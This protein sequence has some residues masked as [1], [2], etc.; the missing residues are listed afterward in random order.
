MTTRL[1]RTTTAALAI[2]AG[3]GLAT[4]PGDARADPAQAATG[5]VPEAAIQEA[6]GLVRSFSANLKGELQAAIR[7]GGPAHAIGVCREAAP[8]IAGNLSETRGWAVGRT[9]LR[10]RNPRNSPSVRERAVLMDFKQRHAAGE[11]LETMESAAV[12]QHGGRR[13]LHYMKAIPTQQVCLACHGSAVKENVRQAIDA[14]YPADAAT[15]FEP[16]DLR[17]AFTFVKPLPGK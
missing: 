9:A 11:S 6:R 12:I 5:Q 17:G 16:G 2:A 13:Y 15:G 7:E 8:S 3:L 14:Q 10:V 1:L 4:G